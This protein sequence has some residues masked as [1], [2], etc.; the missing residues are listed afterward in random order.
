MTDQQVH[1]SD[2]ATRAFLADIEQSGAIPSN[3]QAQDAAQT[4]LCTLTQR[5]SGGEAYDFMNSMPPAMQYMLKECTIHR[6]EGAQDF[7]RAQFLGRIADQ[8][9]IGS[10]HAEALCRA[11]FH[12]MWAHLPTKEMDDLESQLPPDLKD[13]WRPRY[14]H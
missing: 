5:V 1:V 7:D 14:P 9:H 10:D 11:V 4:I 8:L 13:L 3:T 6:A 12:A 2:E